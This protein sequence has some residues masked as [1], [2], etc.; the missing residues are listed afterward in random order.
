[1]K[2]CRK[3]LVLFALIGAIVNAEA[4]T[5]TEDPFEI[6][7][8]P[9]LLEPSETGVTIV[10][11]TNKKALSWVEYGTGENLETFPV[12]GSVVQK[13]LNS[14]HGLVDA[15]TT[16]HTVRITGLEPGRTYRYRLVSKEILQFE[17]Y[18]VI[19]GDRIASDVHQFEPLNTQKDAFSFGVV[20]DVHEDAEMLDT[21]LEPVSWESTDI[22]MM[23]FA[24]DTL[25]WLEKED[26][27]FE[28][29]IDV[30]VNR[31]AKETPMIF[32]RGNHE[33]R[34][35]FARRLMDYFP[36]S[37]GRFYFSFNHGPV[38]FIVL[39]SGEDKP[40]SHPVYAGLVD[41]DRYR[42]E[43]GEWLKKDVQSEAFKNSLYRIVVFHIPPYLD[44]DWHGPRDVTRCWGPVLNEAGIDL[45]IS[46]HTHKYAHKA[47][48]QEKNAFPIVVLGKEMFLN[49]DVSKQQL[50]LRISRK[51][52]QLVDEF[53]ISSLTR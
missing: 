51:D 37:S 5:F 2:S 20:A 7:H 49:V 44:S 9:Y 29:F 14:R 35:H 19:F 38:H 53:E 11:S 28:G 42:E 17:P 12:W 46:G 18:E 16:L 40:D 30:S 23:F 33:T 52:G 31:F 36:S 24:G 50:A 6:D 48:T 27:I 41:F 10:W 25:S 32:I 13:A 34:G 1:M 26:Q 4:K 47:P 22:D 45:V 15:Y 43:Q 39:D 21:L 8:G 3:V